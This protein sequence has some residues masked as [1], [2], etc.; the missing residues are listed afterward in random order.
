MGRLGGE[1]AL[2]KCD[3]WVSLGRVIYNWT[4]RINKKKF[5][6]SL[7]VTYVNPTKIQRNRMQKY[8]LQFYYFAK[9]IFAVWNIKS[10]NIM[11]E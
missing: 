7:F 9:L 11:F 8:S 6:F 4:G 2:I 1:E 5:Y 3:R 10:C